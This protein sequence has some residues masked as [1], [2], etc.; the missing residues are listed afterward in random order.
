MGRPLEPACLCPHAGARAVPHGLRERRKLSSVL[1][2]PQHGELD[3]ISTRAGGRTKC[4][5]EEMLRRVPGSEEVLGSPAWLPAR[6]RHQ[7]G[8]RSSPTVREDCSAPRPALP[9]CLSRP[10]ALS[11]GMFLV[12]PQIKK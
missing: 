11:R 12:L 6:T 2:A 7:E 5:H 4:Q 9:A 1:P 3:G 8:R 10:V